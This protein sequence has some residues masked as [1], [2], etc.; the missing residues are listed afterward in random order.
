MSDEGERGSPY[1]GTM[2]AIA[3]VR[4]MATGDVD[5]TIADLKRQLEH[6][7]AKYGQSRAIHQIVISLVGLAQRQIAIVAES[8]EMTIDQY[9]DA[10]ALRE[11]EQGE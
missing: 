5:H 9:L 2:A 1:D 4:A 10:L 3:L 8:R 6:L 7:T 11:L